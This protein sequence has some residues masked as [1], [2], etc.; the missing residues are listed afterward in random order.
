MSELGY[1][2]WYTKSMTD[3][4]PK[5]YIHAATPDGISTICGTHLHERWWFDY[6]PYKD[7]V[8]NCPKCLRKMKNNE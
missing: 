5:G 3:D 1:F 2:A 4:S 6:K 8:I 7:T